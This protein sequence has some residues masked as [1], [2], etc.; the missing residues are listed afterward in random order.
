MF[1]RD[2]CLVKSE[3][4][5]QI[6]VPLKC[7]CW[8]CEECAPERR[9]RLVHEAQLGQPTVFATLTSRRR[10]DRTPSWAA[11]ELVKCWR[12]IR[13]RYKKAHHGQSIPFLAVLEETE[14]GWPHLHI[15]ARVAWIDQPWL[16]DQMA[17]LHDSPVVDVRRCRGL[18]RVAYYIAKYI[19]KNPHHFEGTKRYWRSK[20]FLLPDPDDDQRRRFA[21]ARWEPINCPMARMVQYFE[22]VGFLCNANRFEAVLRY[23]VPP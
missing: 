8:S 19:G 20:D 13:R 9:N 22:K 18:K 14:K 4:D 11:Q 15:V 2:Y 5:R 23:G 16:S 10:E 3:H 6:V 21:W 12:T 1:C 17:E 7:R